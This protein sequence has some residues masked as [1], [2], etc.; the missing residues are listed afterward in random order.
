MASGKPDDY[1]TATGKWRDEGIELNLD[2]LEELYGNESGCR[3]RIIIMDDGDKGGPRKSYH[4]KVP[5][6]GGGKGKG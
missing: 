5:H 2:R 4:L 1:K 3:V 6:K